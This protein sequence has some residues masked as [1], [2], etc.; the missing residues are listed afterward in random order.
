MED[1]GATVKA[2]SSPGDDPIRFGPDWSTP[3]P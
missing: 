3:S 1:P 2:M